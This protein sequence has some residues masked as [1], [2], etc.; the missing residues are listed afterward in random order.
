[1]GDMTLKLEPLKQANPPTRRLPTGTR[2]DREL[3]G[4]PAPDIMAQAWE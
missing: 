2:R 4:R 1:M 3:T